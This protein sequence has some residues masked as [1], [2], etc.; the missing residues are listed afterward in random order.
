M[1]DRPHL[2][3]RKRMNG[4]LA[5]LVTV[6]ILVPLGT[7]MVWLHHRGQERASKKY[8]ATRG[9]TAGGAAAGGTYLAGGGGCTGAGHGHS[10]CGGG[11]T[12]CGG[13][14]GCGGGGCGGG[15]CGGGS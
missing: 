1:A 12:G 11:H 8:W 4:L 7:A 6:A 10:G 9:G 5:A 3:Y 15:G 14:A 13:G 2:T